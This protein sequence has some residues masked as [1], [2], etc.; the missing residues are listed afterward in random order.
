MAVPWLDAARYA[1]SFGYQADVDTEGWPYRDWV[2]RALNTNLPWDQ[3]ITWQLA[4]DLLPNATR[5]QKLATAFNRIHRK[6][7]E[8][9]S[10]PEEFLQDGIS[11]RVHTVGT[12]F[13]GLTFECAR[14]H[15]HKYDPISMKEYYSLGAFFNSIDEYG[16]I[17]GGANKGLVLPQ[18]ALPL[19]TPEQEQKLAEQ[20]AAIEKQERVKREWPAQNETDFQTWLA[21]KP[22]STLPDLVGLYSLNEV[23]DGK[24]VNSAEEKQLAT[25]GGNVVIDGRHGKAL[26]LNGDDPISLPDPGVRNFHDPVSFAFWLLPGEAYPH[27]V[28][29]S[30]TTSFDKNY[31]GYELLLENGQLRWTWMK[32]FPGCAASIKTLATV[33]VGEWTHVAVTYDGSTKASGMAIYLN[34]KPA[35]C[36]IIRD[37]L[38]RDVRVGEKPLFGAR[39]RDFGIRNGALDEIHVFKRAITSAE[40]AQI[41]DGNA[42]DN[43]LAKT[44]RSPEEIA[45]LREYYFSAIHP[46]ARQEATE[47]LALRTEWRKTLEGVQEIPVME[48]TATPR[49][50]YVLARGAYDAPTER[51]ERV[52]P[53][54][55]I[56][57]P[58]DAPRNRLGFARWLTS[59]DHPLTTRV[60][61]NRLWQE[62]FGRGLVST[63]ENFGLQGALPSHPELLDWLARDFIAHGWDYKRACRQIVLSATYRQDSRASKEVRERDPENILLARGPVKRLS[64]EQL[65]DGALALGG[66][67]SPKI[68]GPPVHPYQPE[69]SMWKALNN[70]LPEYKADTGEGLWR[71]S[72]YTFWRRTTTPP[73]MLA[74][75]APTREVC[76]VKRQLTSTP[77][78]PLVLLND[79]QFVEAGRALGERMLRDGGATPEQQVAWAYREVTGRAPSE[80]ELPELQKLY[81]EQRAAFANDP[82]NAEK[83]LKVGEHKPDAK[84]PATELAAAATTASALL[85]LDAAFMLR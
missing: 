48:E 76:A 1:D 58:K 59:N 25:T 16:L 75:D 79:P 15:D 32:E 57:F 36:D 37:G 3:F 44:E 78:Q 77:L 49:P 54:A 51:V 20:R 43:L 6:T 24:A 22:K 62:F 28:V 80:R 82:A 35:Q 2:V 11:D 40:V 84:F 83:L 8:G 17:Q 29:F 27:A 64:A 55:L 33:P 69:G 46:G 68:G 67:L 66:L 4:G 73:N 85:N 45:A 19:P 5:D 12:V 34:G 38:T 14:C 26:Q 72:I 7:N 39:G 23:K 61:M 42:L 13:L 10:V 70:F 60:L 41:H 63:P 71:R 31:N 74:F 52:T 18:P 9:G 30:N 50:A 81:A 65:R 56:P 21:G 53:A 47:L